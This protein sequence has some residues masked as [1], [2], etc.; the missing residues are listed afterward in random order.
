[1][2]QARR[3][4]GCEERE[5]KARLLSV[6]FNDDVLSRAIRFSR[7]RGF[8]DEATPGAVISSSSAMTCEIQFKV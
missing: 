7:P 3:N 6:I 8:D 4:S 1:V 2:P 5:A